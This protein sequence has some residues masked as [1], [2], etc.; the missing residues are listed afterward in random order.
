M[1]HIDHTI[2]DPLIHEARQID[3]KRR[4]FNFHQN[5]SDRV[6]RMLHAMEP[7]TFVQPHKH[8]NPDKIEAFLV[9]KGRVAAIEYDDN[10]EIT[11]WMLL[12][13][14]TGSF[15][16]E[17]P[18]KTWHSLICL[19]SGTIVYEVKD[20]PWNPADDKFFAPWSPKEGDPG[21][22]EYNKKVLDVLLRLNA[23]PNF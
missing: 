19:E 20:G 2:T 16:M 8:E 4:N 1:I 3:R 13:P 12:D 7:E 6:H 15:G 5:A 11:D 22:E 21:C 23:N 10:G 18:A 17:V 14:L 9:L